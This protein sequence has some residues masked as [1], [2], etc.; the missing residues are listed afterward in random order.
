MESIEVT[1]TPF[2]NLTDKTNQEIISMHAQ[3]VVQNALFPKSKHNW[4]KREHILYE[5]L[6]RRMDFPQPPMNKEGK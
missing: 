5:E 3:A 1:P 2:N 6:I 4:I